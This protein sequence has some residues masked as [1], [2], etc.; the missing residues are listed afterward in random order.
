[1]PTPEF[2]R[3]KAEECRRLR[4]KAKVPEVIAQ[5]ELWE[6]E[7]EEEAARLEATGDATVIVIASPTV[8]GK[9]S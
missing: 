2:L 9:S 4:A 8:P 7:F 3:L 1:M 5:L 6:R